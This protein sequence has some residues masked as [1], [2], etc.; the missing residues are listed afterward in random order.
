M[1]PAQLAAQNRLNAATVFQKIFR[2]TKSRATLPLIRGQATLCAGHHLSCKVLNEE[3]E[4]W[5]GIFH[6]EPSCQGGNVNFNEECEVRHRDLDTQ[7]KTDFS[8][9]GC[10]LSSLFAEVVVAEF[11]LPK[12]PLHTILDHPSSAALE[13]CFQDSIAKMESGSIIPLWNGKATKLRPTP[14]AV[15]TLKALHVKYGFFMAAPARELAPAPAPDP[16]PAPRWPSAY[17]QCPPKSYLAPSLSRTG[18][19]TICGGPMVAQDDVIVDDLVER[20]AKLT[21]KC[22]PGPCEV[23]ELPYTICGAL[24]EDHKNF[25]DKGIDTRS[26]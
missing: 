13:N 18:A 12:K 26:T 11:S 19:R 20:L 7:A 6:E 24:V 4:L 16:V 23:S 8:E 22:G 9:T 21:L 15:Q 10:K 3:H 25:T 1:G 2:G 14:A 5:S 17:S